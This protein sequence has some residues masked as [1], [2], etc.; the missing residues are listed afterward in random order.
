[1]GDQGRLG[2]LGQPDTRAGEAEQQ[3]QQ[4]PRV[5][6]ERQAPVGRDVGGRAGDE[7]PSRPP[8][9][10]TTVDPAAPQQRSASRDDVVGGVQQ[11]RPA[12]T[13]GALA[14]ATLIASAANSPGTRAKKNA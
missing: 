4:R 6:P 5:D 12:T 14:A 9:R 8:L 7:D 13:R 10:P 1:M 11:D 3:Q 2:R